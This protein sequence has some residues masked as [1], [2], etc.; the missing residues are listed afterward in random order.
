M[1]NIK[2]PLNHTNYYL[3]TRYPQTLNNNKGAGIEKY[4]F[5]FKVFILMEKVYKIHFHC[6]QMKMK[7]KMKMPPAK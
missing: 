4:V 2:L 6:T 7:M 3:P 5:N 1:F